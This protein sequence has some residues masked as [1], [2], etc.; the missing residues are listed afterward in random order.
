MAQAAP[1]TVSPRHPHSRDLPKSGRRSNARC[2]SLWTPHLPESVACCESSIALR[3]RMVEDA[4]RMLLVS[5]ASGIVRTPERIQQ[6]LEVDRR[7]DCQLNRLDPRRLP[8]GS[9]VIRRCAWRRGAFRDADDCLE[10][11]GQRGKSGAEVSRR[12]TRQRDHVRSADL[13]GSPLQQPSYR[14]CGRLRGVGRHVL[15][16]GHEDKGRLMD[17]EELRIARPKPPRRHLRGR[18]QSVAYARAA[19]GVD[20]L[21]PHG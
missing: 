5:R 15:A 10:H 1:P 9:P 14:W 3:E 7:V 19:R 16:T 12:A 13:L 11:S 18:T 17:E 8:R 4:R 20:Q 6:R 2:S 21:G